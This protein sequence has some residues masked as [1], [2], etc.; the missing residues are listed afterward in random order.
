MTITTRSGKGSALTNSELD[1]NF[2][3]LG[4]DGSYQAPSTKGTAGQVLR[5]NSG[6]T[7]LEFGTVSGGGG[8]VGG[9]TGVDFNDNV[10][11]RLGTGN[12]AELFFDAT[13]LNIDT[14][15]DIILDA[16]ADIVLKEGGSTYAKLQKNGVNPV[17]FFISH[18]VA[19]GQLKIRGND[20]GSTINALTINMADAGTATFNKHVVLSSGSVVKIGNESGL[21]LYHTASTKSD[22][23]NFTGDFYINNNANDKDV[24]IRSDNGSGGIANYFVADGSTGEAILYHYGSQKLA[25]KS[26]GI[27]TTGTVNVNGAYTLPTSDGT[28]GQVLTTDG[29]GAVTF[30]DASGGGGVTGFASA[31]NTSSPNDT[32]NVASLSVN[33]SST[34]AGAAI[35]PKGTGAFMLGI[36]D[37]G[38]TGGDVRGASAIDLG[39]YRTNANQVASGSD[40]I[41]IGNRM[42][43][44]GTEA[45]AMGKNSYAS[46][47]RAMA[48]GYDSN[49]S[50]N[51]SVNLLGGGGGGPVGQYGVAIGE[52]SKAG[53]RGCSVN[54]GRSVTS[55]AF[56]RGGN[57]QPLQTAY[58]EYWGRTTDATTATISSEGLNQSASEA[59]FL[60]LV[61][62]GLYFYTQNFAY[63]TAKVIAND[64]T[65]NLLRVW[66]LSAAWRIASSDGAVT[67]VGTTTKTVIH[68][69]GS[70]LNSTDVDTTIT[71]R[72]LVLD[73]T[74][75]A[76]T[77][78][79]WTAWIKLHMNRYA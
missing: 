65:N 25:T 67:Q 47:Y 45:I 49:A 1:A 26:T 10:K 12:D 16:G 72:R 69:E 11:I 58:C 56:A 46:G 63:M 55:H 51:Y 62:D 31:D 3:H 27:Q 37:S 2:T 68:S 28:N 50:S 75:V 48:V 4:G 39:I 32:T 66:D 61:P 19:D 53:T 14:A 42:R 57:V 35:V 79:H 70:A 29:S 36:P 38:T 77:N 21:Q 13:N 40:S 5:M 9:S 54:R 73:V 60:E 33:S 52:G 74:G 59:H 64:S 23:D 17:E 41:V 18:E 76:S 34:N 7:A 43:A 24:F 20:N 6:A 78:I 30:A 8:G 15:G 22:I 44:S 71:T